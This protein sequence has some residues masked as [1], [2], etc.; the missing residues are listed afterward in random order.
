MSREQQW[1]HPEGQTRQQEQASWLLKA[2]DWTNSARNDVIT[3]VDEDRLDVRRFV[4]ELCST[5]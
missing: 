5:C 4:F 1:L 3:S 2:S